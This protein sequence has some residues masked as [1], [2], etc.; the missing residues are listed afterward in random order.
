MEWSVLT[1]EESLMRKRKK[2]FGVGAPALPQK[3]KA[4]RIAGPDKASE[5]KQ[6]FARNLDQLMRL[7]G[8][9]RKESAEEMDLP[10]K[11]IR[12]LVSAGVSRSDD[13][14]KESL[15]KIVRYFALTGVSDL[16]IANLIPWLLGSDEGKGFVSKF[17]SGLA[18]HREEQLHTAGQI[19]Q[20]QL[21]LLGEALGLEAASVESVVASYLTKARTI[22][23][24]DKADQFK[25]LI[26]DYHELIAWKKTGTCH[27]CND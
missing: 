3:F 22:L 6:Q 8:L 23:S 24:S 14:N 19:D 1:T 21:R 10:Y 5:R 20:E 11:L 4:M 16:W 27:G 15:D 25:Q 2:R 13:R 26:N 9:N 7:I 17:R 12:R 18:S